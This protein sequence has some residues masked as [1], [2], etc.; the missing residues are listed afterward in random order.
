MAGGGNLVGGRRGGVTL[1]AGVLNLLTDL[2]FNLLIFF[3]VCA[4]TDPSK[5]RKQTIP[6]AN[7]DKATEQKD[8]SIEVLLKRDAILVS[9]DAVKMEEVAD[10]IKPKLEGKSK[11]DDRIVVIRCKEKDVPYSMWIKVTS[12]VERAGGVVT[13][14]L[15]EEKEITVK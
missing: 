9:G 5:G 15:E 4:S 2:A 12:E 1:T 6:S 7:K 13:L 10:K 14:Q 8:Q 3:V 11:P